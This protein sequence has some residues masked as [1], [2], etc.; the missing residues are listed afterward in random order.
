MINQK[1]L[2]PINCGLFLT[3]MIC[4]SVSNLYALNNVNEVPII[5]P[6]APGEISIY[7]DPITAIIKVIERIKK[8]E[9]CN[10]KLNIFD[11]RRRYDLLTK[12]LGKTILKNDRPNSYNGKAIICGTKIIPIGGHR[13]KSKWKPEED[14]FNDFKIFF[15]RTVSGVLF[16]VR[17]D[18][19]RWFGKITVRLLE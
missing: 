11:G 17:V 18:L 16:P 3:T 10:M 2:K 19:E 13:L 1:F 5:Q 7:L 12:E 14:N 9:P 15:G 6:G 8:N 4:L